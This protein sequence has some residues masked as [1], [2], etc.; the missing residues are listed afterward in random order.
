MIHVI[1]VLKLYCMTSKTNIRWKQDKA[2]RVQSDCY[3][4]L[5]FTLR[6]L[7]STNVTKPVFMHSAI[8]TESHL[9]LGQHFRVLRNAAFLG[10]RDA[11]CD[12]ENGFYCFKV[13]QKTQH[14]T[15]T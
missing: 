9:N 3:R 15:L 11:K 12:M 6:D 1:A 8:S 14:Q 10:T 7:L 4:D 5:C 2:S 13:T